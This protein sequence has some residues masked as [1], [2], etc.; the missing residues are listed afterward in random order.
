MGVSLAIAITIL[1]FSA[2]AFFSYSNY[3]PDPSM[4]ERPF[5]APILV[6]PV[7]G[8]VFL[9]IPLTLLSEKAKIPRFFDA[10]G[11]TMRNG[12]H[13]PWQG[14]RGAHPIMKVTRSRSS[15]EV[16]LQLVFANGTAQ[17]RYRPIVNKPEVFAIT[18]ALKRG[19]NPFAT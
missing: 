1:L 3:V 14:F 16:G 7:L 5:P 8:L 2:Y 9:I 17:I 11:V 13:L 15:Y 18:E 4:P 19:Q 12:L 6:F 10:T